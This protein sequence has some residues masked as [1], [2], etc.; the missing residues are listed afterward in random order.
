VLVTD[1][2]RV[3]DCWP[4]AGINWHQSEAG[5]VPEKDIRLRFTMKGEVRE[6]GLGDKPL[7]TY[8]AI[9]YARGIF[10]IWDPSDDN[11][12]FNVI[13]MLFPETHRVEL[14]LD[15]GRFLKPAYTMVD[16][17]RLAGCK[18]IPLLDSKPM[19]LEKR[20]P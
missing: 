8:Y 20:R 10:R 1:F 18:E 7:T 2:R 16:R 9:Y 17:K 13:G 14:H 4:V 6:L 11:S 15:L 19:R 5:D 3:I 12:D